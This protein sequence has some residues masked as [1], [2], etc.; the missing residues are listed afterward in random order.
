MSSMEEDFRKMNSDG[1][2]EQYDKCFYG[3]SNVINGVASEFEMLGKL[4]K[5]NYNIPMPD[6]KPPAIN[7]DR[8]CNTCNKA[9]VCMYKGEL[10]KAAKDITQISERKNVF[11]DTDIR[12]KKWSGKVSN[13][14][15]I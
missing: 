12:C 1:Y 9:D 4:P 6:V 15:N 8:I 7:G 3:E 14:R 13:Y 5:I 11:I 2:E 10:V